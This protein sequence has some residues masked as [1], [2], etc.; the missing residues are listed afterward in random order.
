VNNQAS[1]IHGIKT[2]THLRDEVESSLSLLLLKLQGDAADGASLDSLHQVGDEASD[3]ISHSL[4]RNHGDLTGDLLVDV[5]VKG[6]SRV[7]SLDDHSGGSLDGL[8]SHSLYIK[9]NRW[10]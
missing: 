7:V 2:N 6:E 4:G 10:I 3:L 1:R 9:N 8:S 5:E